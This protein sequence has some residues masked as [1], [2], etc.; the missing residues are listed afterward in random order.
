MPIMIIQVNSF[1]L[2]RRFT[3]GTVTARSGDMKPWNSKKVIF[4]MLT[5]FLFLGMSV[6]EVQ[7]VYS[8]QKYIT[9]NSGQVS[10]GPLSNF[11]M[12]FSVTDPNLATT[13]NG[14]HVQNVNG[15][16]I[17]FR[18]SSGNFLNYEEEYYNPATGQLIAWVQVPSINNG[19]YIFIQYGDAT[20]NTSQQNK[21]GVWGSDYGGVWHMAENGS[22]YKDSTS[23]ANNSTTG[24][25]PTQG[26]GKIWK[27]QTFDGASSQYIGIPYAGSLNLTNNGTISLWFN[28]SNVSPPSGYYDLIQ[29]GPTAGYAFMFGSQSSGW[30]GMWFGPQD[31]QVPTWGTVANPSMSTGNWYK[32]DGVT[33]SGINT[34]YI[35]GNQFIASGTSTMNFSN[36]GTLQLCNGEDGYVYGTVDELRVSTTQARSA[37]WVLTEY[38]NQNNPAGFY[39]VS[40]EG[41][42]ITLA[43]F[44]ATIEGGA[45]E[46]EWVTKTEIDNL[47]FNLYR[48]INNGPLVQLNGNLIPGLISSIAGRSYTY[49]DTGAPTGTPVCYTLEDLDLSG[50]KT[51]HGPACVYAP[52]ASPTTQEG[53]SATANPTD[54]QQGGTGEATDTG[55]PQG[56]TGAGT[57]AGGGTGTGTSPSGPVQ[58]G[59]VTSVKLKSLTARTDG[60][61][62]L[63]AWTTGQEVNN[64]GFNVYR[65]DHGQRVKLTTGPLAGSALRTGSAH[66]AAGHAYRFYDPQP[67]SGYWVEDIDLNGIRT[68]HG[69]VTP[70]PSAT[71]LLKVGSRSLRSLTGGQTT[72]AQE[73]LFARIGQGRLPTGRTS[74]FSGGL[75]SPQDTQ[76][77]LAASNAV[78]LF[79]R[80][81]GWYRVSLADLTSL[82]LPVGNPQF[83]QLYAG[84]KEQ[85]LVVENGT[86]SF[87]GAGV[88]TPYTD[89]NVYWL[90]AGS[91]PGKRIQKVTGQGSGTQTSFPAT[92]TLKERT[93]YF[94]ALLNGDKE[95]F[96]G[97]VIGS[98]PV[99]TGLSVTH[100]AGGAAVLDLLL[101]GV[102]VQ[103]HE[104]TVTFN[105]HV[106]GHLAFSGQNQGE[107]SF[108][109]P[110]AGY[111]DT[112]TLTLQTSGELDICMIDTIK[113]TYAKTYTADQDRLLFTAQGAKQ[114][115][116]GGFSTNQVRIMDVTDPAAAME[117]TG[118]IKPN[119]AGYAIRIGIPGSGARSLI[120]F[121]GSA[122]LAPAALAANEPSAWY[123]SGGADLMMVS[124]H[125]FIGSLAPLKTLRE[126]T[127][128]SVAVVDIE[129]VY[130]E[131]SFGIKTPYAVKDFMTRAHAW[132]RP[133]A[134]LVLVGDASFDPKNY[135]GLGSF[136]FV[137]TKLVD[138]TYLETASD[139]WFVDL[140]NDLVP[141]IPIGRLPVRTQDQA[142]LVVGKIV[143]YT[144]T[145]QHNQALLVAD[146]QDDQGSF[147]FKEAS[148]AVQALLPQGTAK[149][150]YRGTVDDATLTAN[151]LAACNQ[152]PL[153]VNY[154]GHGSEETWRGDIFTSPLAETLAN[155]YKLPL[156]VAMTCLNGLF[157]DVYTESLAEALI[158]A[159]Q[160]GA[161]AVF[162]SSGLTDPGP[163]SVMNQEFIRVLFSGG[164]PTIGQAVIRA[165]QATTDADVRKTWIFFGDP[166]TKLK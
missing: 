11:P 72:G 144:Q 148:G 124:H 41:T 158:L 61:G 118:Q 136:D 114:V 22:P 92:V 4:C 55:T 133:P 74:P 130:D 151:L 31:G 82:G 146:E 60:E 88:A 54:L 19:T 29:M 150:F 27:G 149:T 52:G 50:T 84:G 153:L 81:E 102:T 98:D 67:G 106:V 39:T 137:P 109:I 93:I 25:Y 107:A 142:A 40:G 108:T 66:L 141:D 138:A 18:D 132:R 113:L 37:G 58:F 26:N 2:A 15:Y 33:N 162:A 46:V 129:D 122:S 1:A 56:G 51:S 105:G 123:A 95:N 16:D 23:N 97:S 119:G 91:Q 86:L 127:G 38:N 35:N 9:V 48:S 43:S 69:P 121:T 159:P 165:K 83:L 154:A 85:P 143:G 111:G 157:Q 28:P 120:A 96:F 63:I 131:F 42:V 10:G 155:G 6:R 20:I 73:A 152:G 45:V 8:Y 77:A 75:M 30:P 36:S 104:V 94:A 13:A 100:R 53:T 163:Q 166:T 161:I 99:A 70:T 126:Q 145:P 156:V 65:Q 44:S 135:L 128:L 57:T 164:L 134:Y 125:D 3:G 64:L 24:T 139:D 68:L 110:E 12:L 90:V 116:V 17:A 115:T 140:N 103:P 21:T 80:D 78:K 7:A 71:P 147:D 112:N 5:L 117:V 62:V 87:Y 79:I 89:T 101:Q 160:G 59:S 32:I 49:T 34:V 47:G 76:R 14:G